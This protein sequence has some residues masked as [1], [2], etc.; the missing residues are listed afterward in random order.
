MN[1]YGSMSKELSQLFDRFAEL[2]EKYVVSDG[3][4][5][6]DVFDT[7]KTTIINCTD[8]EFQSFIVEVN[9]VFATLSLNAIVSGNFDV[10]QTIDI[11]NIISTRA[12]TMRNEN[13]AIYQCAYELISIVG[14]A[15]VSNQYFL[16]TVN[17]V[18]NVYRIG[19]FDRFTI[20]LY[21][22]NPWSI[23]HG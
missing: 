19:S 3:R 22:I 2:P 11:R 8:L 23:N 14:T 18:G 9:R 15:L 12:F 20:S 10:K 21:K 13:D 4:G 1:T 16:N 7:I 6:M 17:P 5:V